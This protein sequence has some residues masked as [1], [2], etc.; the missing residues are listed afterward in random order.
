MVGYSGNEDPVAGLTC[1]LCMDSK[2]FHS[3]AKL[4]DHQRHVHS[5]TATELKATV[6][7]KKFAEERSAKRKAV[8]PYSVR[9]LY[10]NIL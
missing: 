7:G 10:T 9:S 2:K 4:H 1:I 6:V 8:I 5:K 3:W